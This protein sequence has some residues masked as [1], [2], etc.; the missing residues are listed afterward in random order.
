[1]T[2]METDFLRAELE[3]LFDLPELLSLS[4]NLLGFDPEVIGATTTKA[5]FAGALAAHC[6]EQDAVEA[7]CDALLAT[8]QDVS[9]CISRVQQAGLPADDD[10]PPGSA[11][12]GFGE[13]RRL[14]EG[15]LGVTYFG[16]ARRPRIPA[17][18]AAP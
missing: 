3:R 16:S 7:L 12:P 4:K 6:L 9:D 18:G 2:T 1:M 15:R 17:E 8:R 5:S 10:L 14:G 11:P 13:L